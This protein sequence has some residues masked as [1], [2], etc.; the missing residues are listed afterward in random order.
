MGSTPSRRKKRT[1]ELAKAMA[2]PFALTPFGAVMLSTD[3]E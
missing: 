3:I 1:S 2:S